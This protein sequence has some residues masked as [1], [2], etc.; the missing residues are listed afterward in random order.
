MQNLQN[1]GKRD[2]VD[3]FQNIGGIL[4]ILNDPQSLQ[5]L[6]IN[7]A[8]LG[9]RDLSKDVDPQQV[10]FQVLG[11][12]YNGISGIYN[13]IVDVQ[14]LGSTV[15]QNLQNQGKRDLSELNILSA[16]PGGD[17]LYQFFQVIADVQNLGST[18]IENLQNLGKRDLSK[19]LNPEQ[20][21]FFELASGMFY[22]LIN[23]GSAL[24]EVIE[25]IQDLGK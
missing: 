20:K 9:K 4:S 1:L 14:N 19:D 22:V 8:V 12:I 24:G 15:M 6:L 23:V 25:N 17:M 10:F 2:L 13:G 7:L 11:G 5:L 21:V 18:V 3:L 16:F